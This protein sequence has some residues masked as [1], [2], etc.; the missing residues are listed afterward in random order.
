MKLV[1]VEFGDVAKALFNIK[2]NVGSSVEIQDTRLNQR[3]VDTV[4]IPEILHRAH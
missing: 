3:N 1:I 4:Q 2:K